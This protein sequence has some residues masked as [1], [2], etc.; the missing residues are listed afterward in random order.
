MES[1]TKCSVCNVLQYLIVVVQGGGTIYHNG[2][3]P[4]IVMMLRP[5]QCLLLCTFY[6]L[7][8]ILRY[9]GRNHILVLEI[10]F[11]CAVGGMLYASVIDRV[12]FSNFF[13]HCCPLLVIW[14]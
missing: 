10:N 5:S 4:T 14:H 3:R 8:V 9:T 13:E 6:T 1:Y 7:F 11:F 12:F 2:S